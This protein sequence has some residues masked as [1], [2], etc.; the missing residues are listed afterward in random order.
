MFVSN[1]MHLVGVMKA[2]VG[3]KVEL[4][5][6]FLKL[7]VGWRRLVIFIPLSFCVPGQRP[8]NVTF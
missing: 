1:I 3:D 8:Q 6:F 7:G 2:F 4:S 5:F